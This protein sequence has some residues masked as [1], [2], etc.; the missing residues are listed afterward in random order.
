MSSEPKRRWVL[1]ALDQYESRLLRY[2]G[3]LLGD[4][5]GA[6]DEV[7]DVVQ[8]VFLRLCDQTPEEIGERLAQWLYTVCRN[9]VMDVLRAGGGLGRNVP[10]EFDDGGGHSP[11]YSRECDPAEEVEQADLHALLRQL[12]EKL[13]RSQREVIDLWSDGF[14]YVQIAGIT[15]QTEGH[16][17]VLVHRGLKAIREHPRVREIVE[18]EGEGRGNKRGSQMVEVGEV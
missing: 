8:F 3:R 14:S 15:S 10:T 11:P 12:I 1:D 2:A 4:G 6:G 9:R 7:R 5:R 16:I 18:E 17:R 13:P